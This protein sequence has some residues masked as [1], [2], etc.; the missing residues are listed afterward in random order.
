MTDI[1]AKVAVDTNVRYI[2]ALLLDRGATYPDVLPFWDSNNI[3]LLFDEDEG[4]MSFAPEQ[5]HNVVSLMERAVV[6]S[7]QRI[8]LDNP[9]TS[10]RKKVDASP[11]GYGQ[12]I[13]RLHGLRTQLMSALHEA[14][15]QTKANKE[16]AIKDAALAKER[17]EM[18]QKCRGM[19]SQT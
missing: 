12:E 18:Q 16:R 17:A 13:I 9:K 10:Y 14:C 8:A 11:H 3:N 1:E 15:W 6:I 5:K 4:Y 7:K 2:K 19:G